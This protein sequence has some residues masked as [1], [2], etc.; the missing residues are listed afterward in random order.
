MRFDSIIKIKT[1]TCWLSVRTDL[2][3]LM[4]RSGDQ[5]APLPT[6]HQ[7]KHVP[8]FTQCFPATDHDHISDTSVYSP[9]SH[10]S[11]VCWLS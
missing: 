5:A 4:I 8:P 2:I 7:L 1:F 11:S 9:L 6:L 10:C 3:L